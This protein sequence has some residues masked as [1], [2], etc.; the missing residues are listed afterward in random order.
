MRDARSFFWSASLLMVLLASLAWAVICFPGAPALGAGEA[1]A[2]AATGPAAQSGPAEAGGPSLA[3]LAKRY[4]KVHR[5]STLFTAQDVRRQLTAPED[6][7]KAVDWCKRSGLRRVFLETHR[8]RFMPDAN[9]LIRARDRFRAEGFDVS[10]CVTTTG[11][12]PRGE[13][14][15]SDN[16][17]YTAEEAHQNLSRIFTFTAGLF[18]EIIIDDF[19]DTVC[20]CKLC[21][22]ARKGRDWAQYRCDLMTQVS[23]RYI[24]APA[25]EANPKVRVIIKYPDWYDGF[26]KAG[27]DV[28]RET[29]LYPAIWVGTETREPND[30]AWG[31]IQQYGAFFG[32]RWFRELGA[33]KTGGGWYDSIDTGAASY[34]EQARQT[35]LGGAAETMLFAFGGLQ[36]AWGKVDHD[37]LLAEM[38]KLWQ[39]AEAIHDKPILG[40]AAPK[41]IVDP[42]DDHRIF[43]FVGMIGVPLVPMV[44]LPEAG[45]VKAVF[46]AS[47]CAYDPKLPEALKAYLKGGTTVLMTDTLANALK[48]KADLEGVVILPY[49]NKQFDLL[50]EGA[51]KL[52]A[53]RAKVLP[54][55]GMGFEGRSRVSLHPFGESLAAV[56]NFNNERVSV[57]VKLPGWSGAVATLALGQN[58]KPA[59]TAA[60]GWITVEIGPRALVLLRRSND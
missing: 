40:V 24:L 60:D 23:Q 5:F 21:D 41:P 16:F 18:D 12:G 28:E 19:L 39:L 54:A 30:L 10:G 37:A 4:D 15:R 35:I 46:L 45:K 7:S 6:L 17:C 22:E 52:D 31:G 59:V 53:I 38:P 32:M 47:H 58:D 1:N 49:G 55:L 56:E 9:V 2:P 3:D 50:A 34:L 33:A 14:N 29:K 51:A 8:G 43:D 27:Y 48:G 25:R 26:R 44:D 36:R 57:R 20:T 11:V 13:P 42:N